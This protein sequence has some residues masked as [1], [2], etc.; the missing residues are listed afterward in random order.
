MEL[1]TGVINNTER[2]VLF[3]SVPGEYRFCF[4]TDSILEVGVRNNPVKVSNADGFIFGR[5]HDNQRIAIYSGDND[6]NIFGTQM[7]N[8]GAYVISN[9]NITPDELIGFNAISFSGGSLNRVFHINGID[10]D[11]TLK[12]G[13]VGVE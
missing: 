1:L 11:Y 4:M 13:S 8:A 12:D 9:G 5:T 7:L 6:L 2:P 3:S 10:F